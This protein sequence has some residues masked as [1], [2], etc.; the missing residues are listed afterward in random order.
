MEKGIDMTDKKRCEPPPELRGKDG[1]HIVAFDDVQE[2]EKW[3]AGGMWDF[4]G[5]PEH[6]A[7]EGM[8]YIGPY[9]P[10]ATVAA[11]VV[12]LDDLLA[13]TQHATHDCGDDDCPVRRAHAALALYREAGR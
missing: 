9:T 1:F 12:A 10:P 5:K 8:R 4:H 3:H 2:I 11:L 13:D 6:A 7:G